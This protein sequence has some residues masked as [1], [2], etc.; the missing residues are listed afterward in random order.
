MKKLVIL[1]LVFIFFMP[2]SVFAR[3]GCCSWHGGV[4][5]CGRNG[6]QLCNDGTYSPTCTCTSSRNYTRKTIRNNTTQT[7]NDDDSE[8]D[9]ADTVFFVILIGIGCYLIYHNVYAKKK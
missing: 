8:N 2:C 3:Q 9:S 7:S 6:R 1:F 4:A 5:G